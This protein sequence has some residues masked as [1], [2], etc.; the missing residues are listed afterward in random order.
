M[1]ELVTTALMTSTHTPSPIQMTR[2][3][4]IGHSDLGSTASAESE[5]TTQLFRI[6]AGKSASP[7]YQHLSFVKLKKIQVTVTFQILTEAY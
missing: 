7:S 5:C 1:I 3:V 4:L 2:F 6:P